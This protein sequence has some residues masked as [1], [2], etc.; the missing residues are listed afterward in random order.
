MTTTEKSTN[1]NLDAMIY[2]EVPDSYEETE[3]GKLILNSFANY[4]GHAQIIFG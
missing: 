4:C 3:S 1:L 2:L